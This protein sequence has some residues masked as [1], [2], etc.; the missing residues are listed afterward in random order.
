[1]AYINF[2]RSGLSLSDRYT[3]TIAEFLLHALELLN[4]E[5]LGCDMGKILFIVEP[6]E[7]FFLQASLKTFSRF[8]V[9]VK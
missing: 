4:S 2:S 1:M 9:T 5:T 3:G 8:Y 7:E 6:L